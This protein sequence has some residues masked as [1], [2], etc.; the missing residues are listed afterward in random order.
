MTKSIID[1]LMELKQLY[2]QGILTKEEM[3]TEKQKILGSVSDAPKSESSQTIERQSHVE[4]K[5]PAKKP[6]DDL[7]LKESIILLSAY[8]VIYI[9]WLILNK[10][11]IGS[12]QILPRLAFLFGSMG[13]L[14]MFITKMIKSFKRKNQFY[15]L[16]HLV[17]VLLI[18]AGIIGIFIML[19]NA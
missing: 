14:A 17:G 6:A 2:E 3:E 15:A 13:F 8:A 11:V 9:C 16:F 1:K 10:F 4:A 18:G 7:K 5:E 12:G 19:I